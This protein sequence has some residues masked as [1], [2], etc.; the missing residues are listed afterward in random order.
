MAT[1]GAGIRELTLHAPKVVQRAAGGEHIVIT[2]CGRPHGQLGPIEQVGSSEPLPEHGRMSAW[3]EERRAFDRL[4][5]GL[6][7]RYRGR[8]VAVHAG[9]VAGVDP[10]HDALFERVWHALQ[11]RTFFIGRVGGPPPIVDMPGF[12]VE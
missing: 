7:R 1:S 3:H 6:E 5:P 9:R 10:D 11:G 4:L 8:H 12:K 2:R